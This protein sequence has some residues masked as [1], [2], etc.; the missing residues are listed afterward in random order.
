MIYSNFI[1][2]TLSL[3]FITSLLFSIYSCSDTTAK[4][5]GYTIPIE[6]KTN[7][8][9]NKDSINKILLEINAVEKSKLLDVVFKDEAKLKGFNG[10]V[11]IAQ[12]GQVIYKKAFGYSRIKTKD[13]LKINSVFQL[14]SSSKT[15]TAAAIMLLVEQGKLKLTDSIQQYLPQ[16]PYHHITIKMLLTHRSGLSN[17]V[18]DCEPYCEKPNLYNGC[19]F[20]NKSML[21][22]LTLKKPPIYYQPNKKFEYCNTNYALL[23]LII[24]KITG[25]SFADYMLKNI[26]K[27]LG[28]NDTWVHNAK[29]DSIHKNVTIGHNGSGTI[30]KTV[31]ADDVVGDKGIY[32]TVDDMFK[33]D[34]ALY[35]DKLL[36]KA[37]I[38]ESFVG[39]SNEHKG[40]RNYGYGWRMIDNGKGNKI[41]Y[42]NGWWHGYNSEFF[43]RLN[44]QTTIIILSNKD[45]R[46]AYQIKDVLPI[47]NANAEAT[48]V[49]GGD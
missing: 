10:V 1:I 26:F 34:Q 33:W 36:K 13:S 44:D 40:T 6:V 32:S 23:P 29:T 11:L 48:E 20:N 22:I 47:L 2:K 43:R 31:F 12:R 9:E 25:M 37:T 21:E 39:Y 15:L 3:L 42:H 41:V 28:M 38:D 30:E 49:V 18:Y 46:M 19:V 5:S 35:S 45:N 24:E 4:S 7:P 27:P 17:Y 8:T 14:S 16:F